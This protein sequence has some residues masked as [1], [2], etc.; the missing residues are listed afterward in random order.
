MRKIVQCSMTYQLCALV[1][2]GFCPPALCLLHSK[3]PWQGRLFHDSPL[4]L[5]PGKSAK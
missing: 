1:L 2:P 5:K 4:I 3:N